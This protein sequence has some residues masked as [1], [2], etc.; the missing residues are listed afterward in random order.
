MDGGYVAFGGNPKGGKITKVKTASTPMETQKPLLKDEDGEG[1]DVHTYRSMIGSLMYLISSRPDIMF[2]VCSYARYQ[3]NQKVSHLYA[4]KRI[5]RYLKGRPKLGLWYPKDSPFDLVAYTDNDC[6]GASLDR[7]STTGGY[8]FL[9]CR[10]ISWQCKKQTVVPNSTIE[11]KYVATSSEYELWRMRM[12]QY[13]QMVDYSPW[14]VIENGNAPPI[15]QV[16]EGVETII[17]PATAEEK[18]QRKLE[19]KARSTLLMGIPNEH[20]FKFNSIKDAKSLVQAIEKRFGGN[21]ATKKTKESSKV[22]CFNYHKRG[23]FAREC[24]AP[25]SQDTKH[26]ES[27]R[28]IVPVETPASVALLSCDGLGGYDWSDQAEDCPTNFALMAYSS[29]TLR[30]LL[31]QTIHHLV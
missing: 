25:R 10:L 21:V 30:C 23:N 5:F 9:R 15:T 7:K 17:A 22:E 6:A 16:V 14:E 11:A 13:I 31:I 20:Q 8:Q 3:V 2:T 29:T 1:V 19:L 28:R 12:E 27:T 26:K 18:A 24:R 4:V